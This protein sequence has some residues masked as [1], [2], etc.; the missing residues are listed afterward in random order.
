MK[1]RAK[2]TAPKKVET[3][4]SMPPR[5]INLLGETADDA[6]Q[7]RNELAAEILEH[8][9]RLYRS[10]VRHRPDRRRPPGRPARRIAEAN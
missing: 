1:A 8:G 10:A 2:K 5:V 6:G 7:S 3:S 9:L 4:L